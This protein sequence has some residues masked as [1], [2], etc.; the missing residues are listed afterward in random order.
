MHREDMTVRSVTYTLLFVLLGILALLSAD[1]VMLHEGGR[2]GLSGP[3]GEIRAFSPSPV[4]LVPIALLVWIV[5]VRRRASRNRPYRP[6][7]PGTE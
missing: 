4:Y 3:G 1:A 7:R 2:H 5:V 6:M